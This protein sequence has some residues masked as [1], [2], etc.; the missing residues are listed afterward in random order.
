MNA[1]TLRSFFAW[2]SVI[3]IGILLVWFSIFMFAHNWASR[4]S[5]RWFGLSLDKFNS[6]NYMGIMLFKVGIYLFNL[7]PY[8]ALRIIG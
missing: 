6:I 5:E 8:L 4:V 3:D 2:C 7:V 1:E